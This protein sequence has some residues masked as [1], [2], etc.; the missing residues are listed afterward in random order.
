MI[1]STVE[2]LTHDSGSAHAVGSTAHR[3]RGVWRI[4]EPAAW[5]G[6]GVIT[7][8]IGA[9][10]TSGSSVAH[11]DTGHSSRE[12]S[13]SGANAGP[14]A[15]GHHTTASIKA[16]TFNTIRPTNGVS[17]G[18]T[19][20][21]PGFMNRPRATTDAGATAR[22]SVGQADAS[23]RL[24]AINAVLGWFRRELQY[25]LFNKAPTVTPVQHSEDPVTG[26]VTGE[27]YG[28]SATGGSVAYTV[29]Q[30]NNALVHVNPGGTF[31]VTPDA[32]TAH[33]GGTVT[34]DVTVDNG[35]GYRLP[36][37]AGRIQSVIHSLAQWFGLS[38]AD[39]TTAVVTVDVAA[40]NKPP[41]VTGYTDGTSAGDGVVTGHLQATDPNGDSL[42]F[43]GSAASALGGTVVVNFNGT[44][45]YT[46][47]AQ[48]R[49]AAA[50]IDAPDAATIDSFTVNVSDGYGGVT[51]ET[52]HVPVSPANGNPTGGA[53]T[54][55]QID[56]IIGVVTGAVTGVADP[57]LDILSYTSNPTSVG[58]GGVDVYNDGSFTYNPTADQRHLAAALGAPF[59]V[60]HD[61]FTISVSDGH[62]SSTA[63]TVVVPVPPESDEPPTGVAAG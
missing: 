2:K 16:K 62:G 30:P 5:L 27:L 49:H 6:A 11:A 9:A 25:T 61:S 33:L 4:G 41:A 58:G 19:S 43:N 40:A 42:N 51:T 46:P 48:I 53:V 10:V 44:F 1:S 35:S 52:I 15:P 37:L 34:F 24:T 56:D 8:G 50:A 31:T 54:D 47:T 29:S 13:T 12:N 17:R 18:A 60:T 55:L 63:I 20:R 59:T 22:V 36:G 45:T 39:T 3:R 57:D 28:S 38:G 21:I 26:I 7:L 32:S 14:A 23:Q